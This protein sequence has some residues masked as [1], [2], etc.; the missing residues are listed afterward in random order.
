M[1][2]YGVTV[3]EQFAFALNLKAA[4]KRERN[5]GQTEVESDAESTAMEAS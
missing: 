3:Y 4:G 1:Q 2:V 5:N